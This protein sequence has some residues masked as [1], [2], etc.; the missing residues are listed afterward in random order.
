MPVLFKKKKEKEGWRTFFDFFPTPKFLEMPSP[1]LAISETGLRLVEFSHTKKGYILERADSAPFSESLISAGDI[2][3]K[4]KLILELKKFR[5]K[6]K[7]R[8]LRGSLPE[9][10][11]YIFTK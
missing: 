1:G 9:G 6:N 11:T 8:Y 7:L 3:D 2:K 5:E 10:K 4:E